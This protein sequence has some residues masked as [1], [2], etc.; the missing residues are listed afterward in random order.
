MSLKQRYRKSWPEGLPF[1]LDLN[2]ETVFNNLKFSAKKNPDQEA[3]I[4]Y[5]NKITYSELFLDVKK[6][7]GYLKR[8][9]NLS[10][11]E[12][13]GIVMQNCPQFIIIYYAILGINCVVVPLA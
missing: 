4:F 7:A 11:G 9:L 3:I 10:Q 8:E 6:I 5:G 2:N 13:I 1:S 12:R